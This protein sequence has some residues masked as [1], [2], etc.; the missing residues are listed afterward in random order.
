MDEPE[1][2]GALSLA[3]EKIWTTSLGS[4]LQL[5]ASRWP[6]SRNGKIIQELEALFRGAG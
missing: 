5:T 1:A 2:S 4:E 3:D 6:C